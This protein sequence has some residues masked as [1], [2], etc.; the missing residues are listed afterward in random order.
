MMKTNLIGKYRTPASFSDIIVRSDGES[1][2]GLHFDAM[3]HGGIPEPIPMAETMP[4]FGE[5]CRWLDIYFSGRQPDFV[6]AYRLLGA[7]PFRSEVMSMLLGI[8][9]GETVTYGYIASVLSEKHGI[10]MA[11]RAVGSAVG[12]NPICLIIPCHRVIGANFQLTGYSSGL[13]NKRALLELEGHDISRY[14]QPP[15]KDKQEK[16]VLNELPFPGSA[17]TQRY[18]GKTNGHS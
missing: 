9:F 11:A 2:V 17:F 14:V 16:S 3:N 4:V 5:A 7:T 13:A 18:T 1:L 15:P 6:P 12:W 8:P 10:K